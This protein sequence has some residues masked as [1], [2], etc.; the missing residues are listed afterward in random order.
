MAAARARAIGWALLSMIAC[1]ARPA[2]AE[3][4]TGIGGSFGG[5]FEWMPYVPSLGVPTT[6]TPVRTIEGGTLPPSGSLFFAGAQA[7]SSLVVRSRLVVPLVGISGAL[8]AGNSSAVV[9]TLDGSIAEVRPWTA[10]RVECLLPGIG[11]RLTRRRWTVSAWARGYVVGVGMGAS[12]ATAGGSSDLSSPSRFG[13]AVRAEL[14]GCRR[15][16][17]LN[18][19]CMFVAPALY[20]FGPFNGGS[21]GLRWE[22][23][24]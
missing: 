19:L 16:D 4:G 23:G 6:S 8:A 11:V 20:E 24:P 5:Q 22:L 18:R 21:A 1:A 13:L 14:E 3:K 2:A 15:L 9:T 7:D 17:P 12:I 10:Y